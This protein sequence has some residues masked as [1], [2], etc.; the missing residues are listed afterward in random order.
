LAGVEHGAHEPPQSRKPLLQLEMPHWPPEQIGVP[1]ADE[2]GVQL[3]PHELT[4]VS[5]RQ[6]LPQR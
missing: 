1:P 6:L 4:E 2:H 3:V 5:E